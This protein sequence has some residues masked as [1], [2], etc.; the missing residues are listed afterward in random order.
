MKVSEGGGIENESIEV[1][2]IKRDEVMEFMLNEEVAKTSG[3]M[4]ALMWYFKLK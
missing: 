2:Y 1:I 3:L 4:F